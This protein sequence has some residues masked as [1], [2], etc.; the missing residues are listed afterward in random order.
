[1]FFFD[2]PEAYPDQIFSLA[3]LKQLLSTYG[4]DLLYPLPAANYAAP[5]PILKGVEGVPLNVK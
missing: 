5:C 4:F 3:V 1:M 2:H